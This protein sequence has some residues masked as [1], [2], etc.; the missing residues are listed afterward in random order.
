MCIR[1]DLPEPDGPMIA[2][3]PPAGNSTET[4]SSAVTAASPSPNT[5]RRSVA[6]T[7]VLRLDGG[8][9]GLAQRRSPFGRLVWAAESARR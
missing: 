5:R 4:P 3:S 8:G 7:I 1:V 9:G 6:L 2:V